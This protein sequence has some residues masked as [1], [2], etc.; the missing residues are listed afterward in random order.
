[1]VEAILAS[2]VPVVVYVSPAGAEATSAGTFITA[3]A[4][5]AAMAPSTNIGAATPVSSTGEDLPETLKSKASEAAAAFIRSIAEERGRNA[6]ALEGTVLEAK[7]YSASEALDSGII[8]LIAR[9]VLRSSR[10]YT[11][12]RSR[13]SAAPAP[14]KP[15]TFR[16]GG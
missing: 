14:W 6:E 16:S 5:V 11:A 1:M 9:D 3:A 4:H 10:R 13:W 15:R 8:D 2:P 12:G 7:A